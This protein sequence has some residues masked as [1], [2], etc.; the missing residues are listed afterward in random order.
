MFT[1][2]PFDLMVWLVTILPASDSR[3]S[4]LKIE[5]VMV[6]TRLTDWGAGGN[7]PSGAGRGDYVCAGAA[8]SSAWLGCG[9]LVARPP[10][11]IG[12]SAPRAPLPLGDRRCTN[13]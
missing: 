13:S 1:G 9:L 3:R 8:R 4:L 11:R 7:R 10:L 12:N 2:W 5:P 6:R